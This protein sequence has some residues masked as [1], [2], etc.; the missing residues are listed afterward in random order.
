MSSAL[1]RSDRD[2]FHIVTG[3]KANQSSAL[4][5]ASTT[6]ANNCSRKVYENQANRECMVDDNVISLL[7]EANQINTMIVSIAGIGDE[8]AITT[9]NSDS[10]STCPT[11]VQDNRMKSKSIFLFKDADEIDDS[12]SIFRKRNQNP[13]RRYIFLFGTLVFLAMLMIGIGFI[14]FVIKSHVTPEQR[15]KNDLMDDVRDSIADLNKYKND[16]VHEPA[17]DRHDGKQAARGEP[18]KDPVDETNSHDQYDEP[19]IH[20][21]GEIEDESDDREPLY[22][23]SG[24]TASALSSLSPTPTLSTTTVITAMP[25]PSPSPLPTP[26]PTTMT[27]SLVVI[28]STSSSS[29]LNDSTNFEE[30]TQSTSNSFYERTISRFNNGTINCSTAGEIFYILYMASNNAPSWYIQ[31]NAPLLY[32]ESSIQYLGY[33]WMVSEDRISESYFES[34]K[35]SSSADESHYFHLKLIQRYTMVVMALS[36][37]VYHTIV[38]PILDVCGWPGIICTTY[39]STTGDQYSVVTEIHWPFFGL[40]GQIP[41]EVGLLSDSLI[42]LDLSNNYI[43][44][45][46]PDGLY[47]LVHLQHLYLH[48][49]QLDGIVSTRIGNLYDLVKLFLNENKLSGSIPHEIGSFRKDTNGTIV[50]PLST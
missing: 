4:I 44:G 26:R 17:D 47:D 24:N 25:S 23:E 45:P 48:K 40:T 6:G 2:V 21:E 29:V 31:Q 35:N 13:K 9:E 3:Q 15:T 30:M 49:N 7:E 50:R 16:T 28:N 12:K 36:L 20:E 34:L 37:N 38:S 10:I 19:A 14:L 39:D 22:S 43:S 27:P 41:S 42:L 33:C 32:E 8:A 1:Q 5:T 46:I 18:V 11:I